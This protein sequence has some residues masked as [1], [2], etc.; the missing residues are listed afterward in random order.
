MPAS[1]TA[2]TPSPFWL[3]LILSRMTVTATPRSCATMMA[4]MIRGSVK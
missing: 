2:F 3:A 4:A 1:C